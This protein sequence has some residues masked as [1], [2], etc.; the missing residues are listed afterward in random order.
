LIIDD[1]LSV[2]ILPLFPDVPG[3]DNVLS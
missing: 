3:M 2:A 1:E